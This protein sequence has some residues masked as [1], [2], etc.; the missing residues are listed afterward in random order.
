MQ[1]RPGHTE[2]A[3][4]RM[5]WGLTCHAELRPRECGGVKAKCVAEVGSAVKAAVQHDVC[6]CAWA[7]RGAE[8][9]TLVHRWEGIPQAT[10]RL[11]PDR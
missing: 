6:A 2:S 11:M 3:S 4:Q 1:N 5:S 7:T 8:W 9:H 10:W